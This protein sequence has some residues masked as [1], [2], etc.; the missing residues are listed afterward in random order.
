M[1]DKYLMSELKLRPPKLRSVPARCEAV[2][3]RNRLLDD[4][5]F[6]GAVEEFHDV[7]DVLSGFVDLGAG[8]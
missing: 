7:H 2:P 6:E 3:W 4:L 5:V 1:I 8:A